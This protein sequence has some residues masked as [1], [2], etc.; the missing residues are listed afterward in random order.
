MNLDMFLFI[1]N[2]YIIHLLQT[3]SAAIKDTTINGV[4]GLNIE[5]DVP[6]KIQDYVV[7]FTYRL[8]QDLTKLPEKLFA[9]RDFSTAAEGKLDVNAKYLTGDKVFEVQTGWKSEKAGVKVEATLNTKDKL[10]SVGIEATKKI[11]DVKVTL[12]SVYDHVKNNIFVGGKAST[13]N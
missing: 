2:H 10:K 1:S 5:F 12:E 3:V 8:G 9:K 13:G 6:F 7:G 4:D 11:N